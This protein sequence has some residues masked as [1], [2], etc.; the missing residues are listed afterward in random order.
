L[1]GCAA[2]FVLLGAF[3]ALAPR[4]GALL[5][6]VSAPDGE[7]LAY[8][9]AVGFR[10][11]ALGLYILALRLWATRQALAIVLGLTVVIPV[12]D[13]ALLLAVRGLSSPWHLALHGASGI[14]F[15]VLALW[16]AGGASRGGGVSTRDRSHSKLDGNA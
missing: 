4:W 6:G 15:A 16:V 1:F 3:F 14:C 5:F 2:A 12:L 10:D 7:G 8:V 9:R 13:L 11:L